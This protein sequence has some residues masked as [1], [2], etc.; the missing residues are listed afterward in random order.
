MQIDSGKVL[1]IVAQRERYLLLEWAAPRG[2]LKRDMI[3]VKEGDG[4]DLVL[5]EQGRT[6]SP[7]EVPIPVF[8]ELVRAG[9]IGQSGPEDTENGTIFRPT[10]DAKGKTDHAALSREIIARYPKILA[11]LAK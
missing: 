9:L 4:R 2:R 11:A 8:D 6:Y 7:V 10:R 3:T 1:E 5:N